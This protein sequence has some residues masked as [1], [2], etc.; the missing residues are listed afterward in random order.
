M[1]HAHFQTFAGYNAWAN[2]EVYAAAAS[3]PDADYRKAR[4][5]AFFTSIH[6]T[7]NHY[8]ATDRI[9]FGRIE[10]VESGVSSLDQI[11][12]QDFADLRAAREAEDERIAAV[13][14]GLSEA[15]LGGT[16]D[17]KDTAGVSRSMMMGHM[18]ATVFNHQTHHRGQAHALLK[19]AGLPPPPLDLPV[20]IHTL[21]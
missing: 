13:T 11:L 15:A 14:G 1:L 9:W 3:L 7:L 20:Y 6:G 2:R 21:S 19:E 17:F 5:A 4:P 10:G 18:L 16:C 12:Y 8:L